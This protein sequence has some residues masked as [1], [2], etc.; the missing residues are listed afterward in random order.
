MIKVGE[1]TGNLGETV[2][3]LRKQMEKSRKLEQTFISAML[4]PMILVIVCVIVISLLMTIVV[5]ELTELLT[6]SGQELP[7]ITNVLI[8]VSSFMSN[9]WYWLAGGFIIAYW[10]F[11]QWKSTKA[12]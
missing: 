6:S 2:E 5:P 1:A 8:S 10:L 3:V 12:G 11:N 7:M 4:Y 9:Y